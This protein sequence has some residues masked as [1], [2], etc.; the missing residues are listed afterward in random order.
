MKF[1]VL[2]L[3]VPFTA[4]ALLY[5]ARNFGGEVAVLHT[6]DKLGRAFRNQVWVTADESTLWIRAAQPTRAWLDRLINEPAV[7]LE[8]GAERGDYEASPRPGK[9]SYV[10]G[11]MADRYTWAEWVLSFAE[12]RDEAVP[13][14][15][16][17]V[18]E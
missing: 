13:V 2:L 7:A 5:A 8:R 6:H 4:G 17:V 12:D 10:N 14:R 11:L 16:D 1:I 15:L 3:I 9:R 18:W